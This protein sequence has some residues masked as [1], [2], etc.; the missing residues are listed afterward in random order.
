MERGSAI[1]SSLKGPEK[2]IIN[3][4]NISKAKLGKLLR[5]GV[6]RIWA[7]PSA[8]IPS[9]AEL[10]WYECLLVVLGVSL[11]LFLTYISIGATCC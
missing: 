2:A 5:D 8:Q 7:F 1:R 6:E 11:L 10:N 4:T 3:Q 9:S